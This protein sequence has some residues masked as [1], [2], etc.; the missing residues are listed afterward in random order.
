MALTIGSNFTYSLMSCTTSLPANATFPS[1]DFSKYDF[2]KTHYPELY[3]EY[4]EKRRHSINLP[5]SKV[6]YGRMLFQNTKKPVKIRKMKNR[7]QYHRR[8]HNIKQPGRTNCT[9]RLF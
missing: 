3:S 4:I 9:Q 5:V 1:T 7:N 6:E 2:C 8:N